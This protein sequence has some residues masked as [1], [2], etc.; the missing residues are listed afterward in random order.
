MPFYD[1]DDDH[2]EKIWEC[3]V[4]EKYSKLGYDDFIEA[5]G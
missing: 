4:S 5:E 1:I 2:L 3:S